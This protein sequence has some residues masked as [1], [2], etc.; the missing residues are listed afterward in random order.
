MP[1][2]SSAATSPLRVLFVCGQNRL[3]SPTAGQ[4]FADWP[5][6]E[7]ASAGLKHDAE[8]PV[9]PELLAWA[10]VVLVMEPAHRRA[11]ASRF[12]SHLGHLRIASLG[13]PDRYRYMA[14]DLVERLRQVVPAHLRRH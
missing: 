14:P 8:V 2:R 9:T 11:L 13:V 12:G 5:G 10:E 1:T 3:R 6:V 7:T 4:V